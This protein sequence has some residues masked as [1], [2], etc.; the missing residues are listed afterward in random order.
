MSSFLFFKIRTFVLY[1]ERMYWYNILI[2]YGISSDI[3]GRQVVVITAVFLT[4]IWFYFHTI[5]LIYL[6]KL[7]A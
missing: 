1:I 5:M 6:M 7:L 4:V 3:I 2:G